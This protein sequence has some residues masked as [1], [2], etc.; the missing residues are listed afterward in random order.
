MWGLLSGSISGLI[1]GLLSGSAAFANPQGAKVIHG[2]VN[3]N[4]PDTSTL[5]IINSPAAII[6]W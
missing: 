3:F 4:H 2:Q 5:S 6:N 1:L